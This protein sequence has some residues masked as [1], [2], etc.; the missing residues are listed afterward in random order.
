MKLTV[1]A[2]KLAR[3]QVAHPWRFLIAA[4]TITL[5]AGLTASTLELDSS[6]EAL[7]PKGAPEVVN[8]DAVRE[9]TGGTRQLIVALGGKDPDA[10]LEFGKDLQK[11]LENV[12]HIRCAD[13]ELPVAFFKDRGLWLT[14]ISTL[15][16]LVPAVEDAV[17]IAKIQ[18]NPLALHLDEEEE[19]RELDA[20]WKKVDEII[21]AKMGGQGFDEVLTSKDGKYTFLVVIPSIKFSDMKAGGRVLEDIENA[22]EELDPAS[23]NIEVKYA[24]NLKVVQEQHLTM[25]SDLR[26]ASILA[27]AFG[28]LI[29]AGFTRR[30]SAP[31]LIGSAL[32]SGVAWTF[33]LAKLLVGHVNIITGFLAAVLIGLGI[34]FGIHLFVRFRQESLRPGVSISEAIVA[35]VKG[36]SAPALTSALTTAGV[37][38]SFAIADFRGFSGFGLI[39]GIGV[40]MTLLSSFLIL[41]PLLYVFH[42]NRKPAPSGT[43]KDPHTIGNSRIS[44]PFAVGAVAVIGLGAI[45]GVIHVTDIPF[46]NNFKQLRG[47]SEATEFFEYVDENLGAG[48]NPAVFLSSSV[49]DAAMIEEAALE[50]RDKGLSNGKASRMGKVVSVSSLLPSDI[51]AHSSYIAQLERILW[52]P[53]LDKAA[54]KG[55]HRADKLIE[56]RRMVRI[57]PWKAKDLPDTVL[58]RFTTLAGDKYITYVWPSERNDADY[59]AAAWE[60]ELNELSSNLKDAGV[61]HNM[62]DETLI[63]AWIYRLV[64]ADGPPLLAVAAALVFLILLIDF[65]SF[66]RALLVAFPL[67]MGMM[68]F[69]GALHSMGMELNMFNMVVIPSIIGIGIDN[70][71]HIY[72]RYLNEGPGS[73]ALVVR[74]TGAA[75]FLASLTTAVG[76]GSSMI[77]HNVGL[78]TLGST[79]VVGITATFIAAVVFF[80]AFLSLVERPTR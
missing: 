69:I 79:A 46:R 63:V 59:Q 23:R 55:G 12:D 30:V 34:D 32:V 40:V 3:A 50:I 28:I 19:K 45:Y 58:R 24:G 65:R 14:D 38:F 66:K 22:V 71:V 43:E 56:A 1:L 5:A 13:L 73:V 18:A 17:K 62:A 48:F 29:L 20:A 57:V 60:E 51:D 10:R 27:L 68:I 25:S 33:A 61:K 75:T 37:F 67:S 77:S 36:T 47:K 76:F 21:T 2:E 26:N 42:R 64:R 35:F 7:L 16:E 80:P 53:K 11:K 4:A 44:R 9:Q 74:T 8:A 6:Y 39:A 52:D 49:K 70:A 41:P 78:Q 72:H 54:E 31:L 15:K